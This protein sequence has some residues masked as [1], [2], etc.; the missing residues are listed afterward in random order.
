MLMIHFLHIAPPRK[1]AD[2]VKRD[3][4]HTPHA[5]WNVFSGR[6][7]YCSGFQAK[8]HEQYVS[9]WAVHG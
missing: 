7:G 3:R 1:R 2:M 5:F 4:L 6:L 8:P 9:E